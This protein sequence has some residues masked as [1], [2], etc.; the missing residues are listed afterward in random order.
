MCDIDFF[1]NY[2]DFYGHQAGDDC[3]RLV[4]QAL[5]ESVDRPR[6]LVAR[7]GGEEFAVLLPETDRRGA[8]KIAET[9]RDKVSS[10]CIPHEN[11]GN[12]CQTL[13]ISI[14]VTTVIP[15]HNGSVAEPVSLADSALYSAKKEGRNRII[16]NGASQQQNITFKKSK[17][18]AFGIKKTKSKIIQYS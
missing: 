8:Y 1:K 12:E 3:L 16:V 11:A 15:G 10:L 2:N 13:T 9:I 5:N 18:K 17:Q 7:Y 6:D 4:A 14:G